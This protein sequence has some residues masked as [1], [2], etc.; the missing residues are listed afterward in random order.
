MDFIQH[1]PKLFLIINTPPPPFLL[2]YKLWGSSNFLLIIVQ[3]ANSEFQR[4]YVPC[5][6][7]F[8]MRGMKSKM[9]KSYQINENS[10]CTSSDG[11]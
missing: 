7:L 11:E 4:N 3:Y 6:T 9:K 1:I 10:R 2:N 8:H 5:W